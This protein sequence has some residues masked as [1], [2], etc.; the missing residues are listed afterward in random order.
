M[1]PSESPGL[2]T[3]TTSIEIETLIR[4][5][6]P[7]A[8]QVFGGLVPKFGVKG[9]VRGSGMEPRESLLYYAELVY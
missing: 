5:I 8:I 6:E 1:I 3:F 4:F 7:N 2:Y 9:G